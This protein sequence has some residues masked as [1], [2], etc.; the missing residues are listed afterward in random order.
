[1]DTRSTFIVVV[2]DNWT[3]GGQ[4]SAA[5]LTNFLPT[6][7][8]IYLMLFPMFVGLLSSRYYLATTLRQCGAWSRSYGLWAEILQLLYKR[9][10]D[11]LYFY[12]MLIERMTKAPKFRRA[13]ATCRVWY[14]FT[15]LGD[16]NFY[17]FENGENPRLRAA[18][19]RPL[20]TRGPRRGP[21]ENRRPEAALS[22]GFSPFSNVLKLLSPNE[23]N[24]Y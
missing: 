14:I 5:A 16:S 24:L 13:L 23:A 20:F 22:L 6:V 8:R 10:R 18:S 21:R 7:I 15:W 19:G 17:T 3:W 1:M 12:F 9:K 2:V 11:T 4:K